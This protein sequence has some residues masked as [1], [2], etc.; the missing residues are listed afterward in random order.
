MSQTAKLGTFLQ[1]TGNSLTG[2]QI[3]SQFG[4]KNPREAIRQ[5][6]QDGVCIYANEATLAK[7]GKTT[8]YRVGRPTKAMVAAA[9]AAS[10]S[11]L[12]A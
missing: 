6:R 12:F 9:Y 3:T 4:L 11:E 10:G 7:G 2:K 1:S 5:L 8:T